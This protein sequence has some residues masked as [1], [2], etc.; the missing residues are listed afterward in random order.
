MGFIGSWC[1]YNNY[2]YNIAKLNNSTNQIK[3]EWMICLYELE[4]AQ[5]PF[6]PQESFSLWWIKEKEDIL[7]NSFSRLKKREKFWS[8]QVFIYKIKILFHEKLFALLH[9]TQFSNK[10]IYLEL[11]RWSP[12]II[13]IISIILLSIIS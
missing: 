7:W 6:H 9:L 8:A 2:C 5:Q 11:V 12:S 13:S 1:Q 3:M 10:D 4:L